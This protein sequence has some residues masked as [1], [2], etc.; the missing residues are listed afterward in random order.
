V[1]ALMTASTSEDLLQSGDVVKDRWKVVSGCYM[2]FEDCCF[3][4]VLFCRR[5][6]SCSAEAVLCLTDCTAIRILWTMCCAVSSILSKLFS[7]GSVFLHVSALWEVMW[8]CVSC[9]AGVNGID[10]SLCVVY[11][12]FRCH[13]VASLDILIVIGSRCPWSF[14]TSARSAPSKS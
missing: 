12:I 11:I 1:T 5:S 4:S 8:T 14:R 9:V 13:H 7:L 6:V 2:Q 3:I 10:C